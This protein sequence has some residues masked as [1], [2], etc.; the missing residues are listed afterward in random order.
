MMSGI[1]ILRLSKVVILQV[2]AGQRHPDRTREEVSIDVQIEYFHV[3]GNALPAKATNLFFREC[4]AGALVYQDSISFRLYCCCCQFFMQYSI[5]YKTLKYRILV[6]CCRAYL[7]IT[8]QI[9]FMLLDMAQSGAAQSYTTKVQ[10]TKLLSLLH[11]DPGHVVLALFHS[12][13]CFLAR[14]VRS[15]LINCAT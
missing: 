8:L 2:Q 12:S 1:C 10:S 5:V 4:N 6:R 7:Q 11:T 3:I 14:M 15:Q 9:S 13:A